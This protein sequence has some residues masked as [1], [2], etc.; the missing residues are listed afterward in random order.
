MTTATDLSTCI[1]SVSD[2][3]RIAALSIIV[4]LSFAWSLVLLVR[5]TVSD[6]VLL[7]RTYPISV[8]SD[9]LATSTDDITETL[10][11]NITTLDYPYE[12]IASIILS[13]TSD[14]ERS[15]AL[16]KY[17]NT[18]APGHEES[19]MLL[20]RIP[21]V[22]TRLVQHVELTDTAYIAA[23]VPVIG[24]SMSRTNTLMCLSVALCCIYIYMITHIN[25]SSS[26]R[27]HF[28]TQYSIIDTSLLTASPYDLIVFT[29]A[30][31]AGILFF[32]VAFL[33]SAP[34]GMAAACLELSDSVGVADF[35]KLC[36]SALG[37][38]VLPAMAAALWKQPGGHWRVWLEYRRLRLDFELGGKSSM[39]ESGPTTQ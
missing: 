13:P 23:T 36:G 34:F 5:P 19:A 4:I 38:V 17:F 11:S 35:Y 31:V 26:I 25:Y 9:I 37:V 24:I 28:N 6:Q 18:R 2:H 22:R 39:K 8:M 29:P 14:H 12:S 20:L 3:A 15:Q 33:A 27:D 10:K 21:E 32:R 7:S 1:K 30:Q 16:A